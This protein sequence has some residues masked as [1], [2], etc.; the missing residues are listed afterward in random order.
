VQPDACPK[1]GSVAEPIRA[2]RGPGA[3]RG[4]GALVLAIAVLV[5]LALMVWTTG[6]PT[7]LRHHTRANVPV[8]GRSV[9]PF[10]VTTP[11]RWLEVSA[12]G[13]RSGPG[14]VTYGSLAAAIAAASPGDGIRIHS[15]LY[16]LGQVGEPFA[17]TVSK[18]NLTIVAE[19]PGRTILTPLGGVSN[20]IWLSGDHT[21]LSG[22]VLRGFRG[23][24]V[25]VGRSGTQKAVCLKDLIFEDGGVGIGAPQR[26]DD[27]SIDGLL[28]ENLQFRRVMAPVFLSPGSL[29]NAV[30]RRLDVDMAQ[31]PADRPARFA[32]DIQN[33]ASVTVAASTVRNSQ[34]GGVSVEA[35]GALIDSCRIG[36]CMGCGVK[37]STGGDLVNT[38]VF[39]TGGWAAVDL[40]GP[41]H[42]RI[43]HCVVESH[44]RDGIGNAVTAGPEHPKGN[45]QLELINSVFERNAGPVWM[46]LDTNLIMKGCLLAPSRAGTVLFKDGKPERI[47]RSLSDLRQLEASGAG[48]GNLDPATPVPFVDA[49]RGD[50]RLRSGAAVDAGVRE[51]IPTVDATG[52]ARVRG[53]APDLGPLECF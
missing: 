15:G 40:G 47:V 31:T 5:I 49:D 50:F 51:G 13:A 29:E 3:R 34:A 48:A 23:T 46:N 16:T 33:G 37:L 20:G 26:G 27:V 21:T 14:G 11:T 30:F 32:V 12:T 17:V 28:A 35:D 52:A 8:A 25:Q 7:P 9:V 4:S 41:G 19:V 22:C 24:A 2:A 18:S 43:V 45:I 42:Y 44:G 10:D 53:K 6:I 38:A 36:P 39:Q 1:C